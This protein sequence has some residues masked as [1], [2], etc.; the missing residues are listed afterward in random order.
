MSAYRYVLT[1]TLARVEYALHNERGAG[2][3]VD[4]ATIAV[5]AYKPG[6]TMDPSY[7]RR[8]RARYVTP[9]LRAWERLRLQ[10]PT[11][12]IRGGQDEQTGDV[13]LYDRD[14]DRVKHYPFTVPQDRAVA[15]LRHVRGGTFLDEATPPVGRV[16][17][18]L[19]VGPAERMLA[20]HAD[21]HP[22]EMQS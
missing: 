19:G 5:Y 14:G 16:L 2:S 12:V 9:W 6:W 4:L 8:M 15:A 21:R 13:F 1:T 18:V 10:H 22:V 20:V 3:R 7:D 11:L 17:R